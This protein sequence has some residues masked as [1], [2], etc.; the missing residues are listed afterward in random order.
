MRQTLHHVSV[1][2]VQFAHRLSLVIQIQTFT[3]TTDNADGL[4]DEHTLVRD[5]FAFDRTFGLGNSIQA[6]LHQHLHQTMR[7]GFG[8]LGLSANLLILAKG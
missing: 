4:A 6:S 5:V 1:E 8:S 2:T 7:A 3:Q